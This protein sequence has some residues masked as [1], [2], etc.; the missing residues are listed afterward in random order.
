[1][2]KC[3]RLTPTGILDLKYSPFIPLY[4]QM[5]CALTPF[6]PWV[7]S[8]VHLLC[9]SSITCVFSLLLSLWLSHFLSPSASV[10]LSPFPSIYISVS[11]PRSLSLPSVHHHI[12]PS[13][14][15]LYTRARTQTKASHVG[16][17]VQQIWRWLC[18]SRDEL[19]EQLHSSL[20]RWHTHTR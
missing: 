16:M 20:I 11:F 15:L 7:F 6:L 9:S 2:S 14:S 19:L 13:V 1:M 4:F 8:S 3:P 12:S 5:S 18:G 17:H 10:P